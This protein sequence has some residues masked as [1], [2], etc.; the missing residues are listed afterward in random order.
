MEYDFWGR[1]CPLELECKCVIRPLSNSL[2]RALW[3]KVLS[4]SLT[5]RLLI[6]TLLKGAYTLKEFLGESDTPYRK[7]GKRRLP[8]ALGPRPKTLNSQIANIFK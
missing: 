3:V 8:W 5:C 2:I 6:A 7:E 4:N 1:G